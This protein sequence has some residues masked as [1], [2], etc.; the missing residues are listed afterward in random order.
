M[1]GRR[2]ADRGDALAAR[3]LTAWGGR[4]G[5]IVAGVAPVADGG[6]GETVGVECVRH[7]GSA[8]PLVAGERLALRQDMTIS[9][10]AFVRN[11]PGAVAR[12]PYRVQGDEFLHG[13]AARGWRIRLSRLPDRSIASRSRSGCAATTRR[14]SARS[15]IASTSTSGAGADERHVAGLPTGPE[16]GGR[17]NATARR[18]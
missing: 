1:D 6:S 18:P 9:R 15:S 12:V 2:R 5:A 13:D 11:L 10:E 16:A 3:P 17:S 4:D 8:P 14:A 7:A